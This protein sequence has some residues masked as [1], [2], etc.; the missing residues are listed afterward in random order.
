MSAAIDM[1]G[2]VYI[3]GFISELGSYE[4]FLAKSN[5]D[6]VYQWIK[7]LT[8]DIRYIKVLV[9]SVGDVY[10]IG[11]GW[12]MVNGVF[13]ASTVKYVQCPSVVHNFK[14]QGT[15]ITQPEETGYIHDKFILNVMPNPYRNNTNIVLEIFEEA[16]IQIDVYTLTGQKIQEL[17]NTRQEAGTYHFS[18]SAQ[19]KG[20]TAGMY[21]MRLRINDEVEIF[22]LV[23]MKE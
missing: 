11:P 3:S 10:A 14:M 6:G 7:K 9:S 5:S 20:F 21:I 2:G 8:A 18:F 17:V 22:R 19:K 16:R 15:E 1:A 23:V 4:Y 12:D 13:N